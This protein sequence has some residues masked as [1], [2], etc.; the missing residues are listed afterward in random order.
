MVFWVLAM[1]VFPIMAQ[2]YPD[3]SEEIAVE[4]IYLQ[5]NANVYTNDQT[6]WFKA[7]VAN[8][9]DHSPGNLSGV[10]HVELIGPDSK[11]VQKSLVKLNKGLG[12]GSFELQ[13]DMVEGRYLVRAYTEWNRN[14]GED[15]MFSSYINIFSATKEDTRKIDPFGEIIL[16]ETP[17]GKF[18]LTT[19]LNPDPTDDSPQKKLPVYLSLDGKKDTVLLKSNKEGAYPLNYEVPD[20]T[21]QVT[22]TLAPSNKPRYTKTVA[23]DENHIDL[24]FFPESGEL[25]GGITNRVAFKALDYKGKGIAVNGKIIDDNGKAIVSFK[26][27][28]L[29]MGTFYMKPEVNVKY[30]A[31][32]TLPDKEMGTFVFDMPKSVTKGHVLSVVKNRE[33]INIRAISTDSGM[34]SMYIYASCRGT[35]YYR[36]DGRLKNGLLMATIPKDGLPE[37]IVVFT[38]LDSN[39][40]PVAERLYFNERP[41]TRLKIKLETDRWVYGRRELT[42]LKVDIP[43]RQGQPDNVNFS[44]LVMNKDQMGKLQ[45]KR[46]NILTHFLLGSELKGEIETPG[47]YFDQGNLNRFND[48]EA[49]LLTQGWRKYKYREIPSNVGGFEPEKGLHIGGTVRANFSKKKKKDGVDMTM[50]A[51]GDPQ[52]FF[53]QKTDSLGQFH[54]LLDDTYGEQLKV[55]IQSANKRGRN[56]DYNILLDKKK[57]PKI[58]YEPVKSI[59]KLDSVIYQLV[60]KNQERKRVDDIFKSTPGLTE[61]DEVVVEAQKLTPE[62]KEVIEKYGEPDVVIPGT[63]IREKEKKWS[64]GLYSVLLFNYPEEITIETFPD[65]F[66]LAHIIGGETTLVV[67]DGIPVD[68]DQYSFIPSIDPSEVKSVELIKFAKNFSK[69]F[70][71]AVPPDKRPLDIPSIGSVIAI[72]THAGNG[73]FGAY[74]SPG[75]LQASIPVF[76]PIREYYAPKYYQGSP[77]NQDRPDLRSLIHWEP[78]VDITDSGNATISFYNADLTG[79][80]MVVVEAISEAGQIGYQEWVYS[81]GE[82][83]ARP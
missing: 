30:Q 18:N 16:K 58:T 7:I 59:E 60:Q 48:L 68:V 34:D 81:I 23:L 29:G 25:V 32:I 42:E 40:R 17:S 43:G 67:I 83:E 27:N 1:G 35:K 26:S 9:I 75:L 73:L 65:G 31:K 44:V 11:R 56:R 64:Y 36:I 8:A 37:G 52:S 76:A 4:K 3:D 53:N 71:E 57:P 6:I 61:L 15:F 14:Y 10:L 41:E 50:M 62:R 19:Q 80:M 55:L 79:E 12:Q 24:Q 72:Y 77:D 39:K 33:N 78:L 49:L 21:Q 63:E 74:R 51:F 82:M 66:M 69:L 22:L 5:L 46:K 38:L 20:S 2:E 47:H 28:T 45:D 54:F 13:E 70:L